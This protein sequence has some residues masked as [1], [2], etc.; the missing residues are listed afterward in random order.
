ML[1]PSVP[2]TLL[3]ALAAPVASA[4]DVQRATAAEEA[5][6]PRVEVELLS[7][8][9]EVA[10]GGVFLVGVRFVLDPQWHV[11]FRNPGEAAIGTEVVFESPGVEVGPVRWPLPERLRDP[12]GTIVTFGYERAVILAAEARVR[13]DPGAAVR[14]VAEAD[15]LVCKV[16]CI[17]GRVTLARTLPV[18]DAARPSAQAAALR[19][20]AEALPAALDAPGRPAVEWRAPTLAAGEEVTVPLRLRCA[21]CAPRGEVAASLFPDR[22]RGLEFEV[23][24]ARAEGGRTILDL[25]LRA[26]PDG[27]E[28]RARLTGIVTVER[29][30]APYAFEVDLP[31]EGSGSPAPS[32]RAADDAGPAPAAAGRSAAPPLSLG[33]VLLLAL[34]GGVILNAMPCVLPVL[35]LKVTAIGQLAHDEGRSRMGHVLAYTGGILAA[36]LALAAVVLGLRAVGTRV[37][38]GFQLQSPSFATVLAGALV[39]FA[40]GLFG[41]WT[42]QVDGS[43]AGRRLDRRSGLARSFGE[44]LLA[45]LLATPCSAPFL[46]TAVGFA[47]AGS[48]LV[49]VAVFVLIGL[50][51]AL[52]FALVALVPAARRFVPRPGPWME[53]M[54]AGLGFLLLATAL[55]LLWVVGQL[56][57]VD[58]MTRALVLML[59]LAAGA[60]LAR[61]RWLG[62]L[63]AIALVA[64]TAV[65]VFPLP[66]RASAEPASDRWS[67]DRVTA[68]LAEGRPVLVDFTADWCITCRA[69]EQL[70]LSTDAVREAL[71]E[72]R[73]ELLVADWTARDETIRAVLAQYG[74][75]GVPL[76]LLYRPGHSA[77]EILPELLTPGIVTGALR[78][79]AP[80]AGATGDE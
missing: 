7:E 24:D 77:P 59:A 40:L 76:Y 35:A 78:R 64:G 55:W 20:N 41:V 26:G 27:I 61:G 5:G 51:L 1:R 13:A 47:F 11:Y 17:P 43:G 73:T 46:G 28:P 45:V 71:A 62:R 22:V 54:Q 49:V 80:Q 12:S 75:A 33:W 21:D 2:L 15:F 60:M 69:N 19:A 50:G 4:E 67:A 74:K 36:M 57:G 63:L 23:R 65:W 48:A 30:G 10:A 39:I 66:E 14:I 18:S 37:G 79:A 29:S 31:L 8:L 70:V 56:N 44:G 53:K 52:P 38:W 32:T 6:D 72:T 16:D 42:L 58:A 34:V 68:L 25:R 3:F 9:D